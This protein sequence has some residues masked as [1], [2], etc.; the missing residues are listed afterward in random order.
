MLIP[1]A[2]SSRPYALQAVPVLADTMEPTVR[3]G[4]FLLVAPVADYA[5][6]GINVLADPFGALV[7][8]RA[9]ADHRGGVTLV[10]DNPAYGRQEVSLAEFRRQ[11]AGKAALKANVLDCSLLPGSL[12]V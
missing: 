11:V 9:Q 7:P 10:S 2:P 4:D 8:C 1:F 6:A 12:R 3:R 5:G